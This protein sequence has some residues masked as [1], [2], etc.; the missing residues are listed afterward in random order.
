LYSKLEQE[1]DAN[2]GEPSCNFDILAY[3][4]GFDSK[5]TNIVNCDDLYWRKYQIKMTV[6]P[7][8]TALTS[9]CYF[10]S[11]TSSDSAICRISKYQGR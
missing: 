10:L 9:P 1:P 7:I 3:I 5:F 2:I 4:Y 6:N 8:F 11:F